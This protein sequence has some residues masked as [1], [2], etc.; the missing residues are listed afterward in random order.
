MKFDQRDR[1]QML[2]FCGEIHEDDGVDPRDYFRPSKKQNKENRK[3][4]QLCRQVAQTLS[5]TLA[6][7][8]DGLLGCLQVE[9]VVPAPDSSRLLVSLRADVHGD[10][11]DL[12][13]T[14]SRLAGQKGRLR[15]EVAA[16]I[17][18]RKTP[19]LVYQILGP[20]EVE[21]DCA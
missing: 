10:A 8:A 11:F 1:E 21:E 17:T 12:V 18:R 16:A 14:E 7:D 6:G 4:K 19:V 2:A 15:C 5:L 9:S 3:A 13:A 20:T